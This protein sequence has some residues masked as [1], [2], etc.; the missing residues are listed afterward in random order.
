MELESCKSQ[1]GKARAAR[2]RPADVPRWAWE[3]GTGDSKIDRPNNVLVGRSWLLVL[4]DWRE[5]GHWRDGTAA[6]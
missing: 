4:V 1:E 2:R 3:G 6:R 5:E